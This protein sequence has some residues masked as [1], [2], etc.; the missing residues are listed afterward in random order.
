MSWLP[1][2]AM[3]AE[4]IDLLEFLKECSKECSPHHHI[5]LKPGGLLP[6][7]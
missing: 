4:K 3:L 1:V 6:G 2:L 7:L 5:Q